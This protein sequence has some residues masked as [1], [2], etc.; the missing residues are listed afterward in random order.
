MLR[1]V[2]FAQTPIFQ[3][4]LWISEVIIYHKMQ[5]IMIIGW[6]D[7]SIHIIHYLYVK[8]T[9]ILIVCYTPV[10]LPCPTSEEMHSNNHVRHAKRLRF[11]AI[12]ILVEK[13]RGLAVTGLTFNVTRSGQKWTKINA[14]AVD[15]STFNGIS[16]I[17]DTY[18]LK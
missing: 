18:M 16:C 9:N 12:F 6:N 14:W 17:L 13:L 15:S 10:K 3:A 2:I 7:I 11:M 8:S 4:I 1:Q 5:Y